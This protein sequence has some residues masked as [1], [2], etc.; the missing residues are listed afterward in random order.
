MGKR[1]I[2]KGAD[3]SENGIATGTT[4]WYITNGTDFISK[5]GSNA[6]NMSSAAW[7]FDNVTNAK[8]QGKT[9]NRLRII[10]SAAGTFY[11]YVLNSRTQSLGT[12]AAT[13]TVGTG[14]IG[15]LKEFEMSNDLS[16]GAGQFLV[17][18][19]PTQSV[20]FYYGQNMPSNSFYKRVGFT[21][22]A[23]VSACELLFDVGYWTNEEP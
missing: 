10:A 14:D 17:F 12:P 16:I 7:T 1:I 2:I 22:A 8:L 18:A 20:S 9:V 19:N 21:D 6:A 5:K 23:V 13:I 4:T 3:F 15:I 11:L